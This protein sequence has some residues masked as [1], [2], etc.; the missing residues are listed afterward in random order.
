M[1][2]KPTDQPEGNLC[3][4]GGF[5][6]TA[7]PPWFRSVVT[8]ITREL[9]L[10]VEEPGSSSDN[11]LRR[12]TFIIVSWPLGDSTTGTAAPNYIDRSMSALSAIGL[13]PPLFNVPQTA[14]QSPTAMSAEA[15]GRL[16]VA[17]RKFVYV[18][19]KVTEVR[20]IGSS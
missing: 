15:L 7:D 19:E 6:C 18:F 1:L 16:I 14:P 8:M 9:R 10:L 5:I 13:S 12:I 3:D 2:L 4:R 11:V 20:F 17:F